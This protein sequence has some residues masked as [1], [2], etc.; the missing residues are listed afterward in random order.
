MDEVDGAAQ[1]T[2]LR[3][4]VT[5]LQDQCGIV[6]RILNDVLSLQKMEDGKFTLEMMP[7]SPEQLVQNT[8]DSFNAALHSKA[9]KVTV[10]VQSLEAHVSRV[11]QP[12]P[13]TSS[14]GQ[15]ALSMMANDEKITSTGVQLLSSDTRHPTAVGRDRSSDPDESS[16][17]GQAMLIGGE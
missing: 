17:C 9:H 6:S 1:S 8:V 7:F 4:L 15:T 16:A 14:A 2:G 5:L 12:Q 10:R 13:E 3:E 11:I